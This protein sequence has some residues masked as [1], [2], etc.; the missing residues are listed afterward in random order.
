MAAHVLVLDLD[1]SPLPG[2][3]EVPPHWIQETSPGTPISAFSSSNA[4][5][6]A[7]VEDGLGASL[8]A[9]TAI[10]PCLATLR[11]CFRVPGFHHQKAKRFQVR[12][13]LENEFDP[14]H[15]LS[16]FDFPAQN[17]RSVK[18]LEDIAGIGVLRRTACKRRSWKQLDVSDFSSNPSLA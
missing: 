4:T 1:G 16:D 13:V 18:P 9:T 5:H 15:K 3:W 17:F 12:V 2:T 14:P 8:P 10:L 6:I 7:T 11:T